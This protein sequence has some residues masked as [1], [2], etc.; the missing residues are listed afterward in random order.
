[1]ITERNRNFEKGKEFD[2]EGGGLW[3]EEWI[4][5]SPQEHLVESISREAF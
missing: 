2:L 4:S 1:L 5:G 3:H